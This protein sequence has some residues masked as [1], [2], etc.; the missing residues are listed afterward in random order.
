MIGFHILASPY[1][2]NFLFLTV[3]VFHPMRQFSRRLQKIWYVLFRSVYFSCGSHRSHILLFNHCSF[4]DCS[5]FQLQVGLGCSM[6]T[7]HSR[8]TSDMLNIFFKCLLKV[9]TLSTFPFSVH[10]ERS[11]ITLQKYHYRCGRSNGYDFNELHSCVI[12][13]LPT[14]IDKLICYFKL[15]RFAYEWVVSALISF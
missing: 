14:I 4:V 5:Y 7:L 3:F 1:K 10:L 9:T 12:E 8:R 11:S 15:Q 13:I 6:Q 2:T